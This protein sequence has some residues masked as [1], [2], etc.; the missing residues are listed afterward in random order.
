M[1]P[2]RARRRF[3]IWGPL[4]VYVFLIFY[5]SSL[6][7]IPWSGVAPDYVSHAVEYCGLAILLARALNDGLDRPV[8]PRR[9]GAAFL[10]AIACAGLDEGWQYF[11]PDRFADY[12]D[13][14]SD[15]AGATIGLGVL[16]LT[17]NLWPRIGIL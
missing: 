4:V 5:L 13:V 2:S 6:S 10:L 16:H 15:A 14:I 8:P 12:R 17:R 3:W 1:S 11:T 9:L 7:S